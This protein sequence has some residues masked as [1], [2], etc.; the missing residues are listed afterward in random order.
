MRELGYIEGVD[1]TIHWR[2]AEGRYERFEKFAA[3]FAALPVDVIVLGTPAAVRPAQGATSTIPIV[4]SYSTDPVGNGF[5]ASLSRPGGNTTGLASLLEEVV[6]KQVELLRATVPNAQRF[7]ILTNPGNSNSPPVLASAQE[8]CKRLGLDLV[9]MEARTL[10]E[11][12][13]VFAALYDLKAGALMVS[14]D[15]FFHSESRRLGE[16]ALHHRVPSIFGQR[17]YVEHGGLMA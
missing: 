8:T 9:L 7:A 2:F 1:L 12:E 17:E 4:M 5:V 11:I 16:L 14:S 3:E 15:A 6:A 13:N 10:A